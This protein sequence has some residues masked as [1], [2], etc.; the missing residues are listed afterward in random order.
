MSI[1]F[2][3]SLWP[4]Q[5]VLHEPSHT[6]PQGPRAAF[7]SVGTQGSACQVPGVHLYLCWMLPNS[8][9]C[10]Q[11]RRAKKCSWEKQGA[12]LSVWALSFRVFENARKHVCAPTNT[13][14]GR[15]SQKR[16][17]RNSRRQC[18]PPGPS[19]AGQEG[20]S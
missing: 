14:M 12:E 13:C 17:K 9:G 6:C 2:V 11:R 15:L 19:W 16:I 1:C 4:I 10:Q 3:S 5:T 18:P 8:S 7:C 20:P